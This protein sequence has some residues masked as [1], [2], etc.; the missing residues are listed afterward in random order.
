MNLLII[1][2]GKEKPLRTA[3]GK[4]VQ[5]SATGLNMRSGRIK[6]ISSAEENGGIIVS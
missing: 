5:L 3:S 6:E 2:T 1:S 4:V